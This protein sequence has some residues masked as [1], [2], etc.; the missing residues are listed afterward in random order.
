MSAEL[1]DPT[2]PREWLRR[3]RSSLSLARL[4][5]QGDVLLE[6]LCFE[7]QQ[8]A[9]KALKAVLVSRSLRFPRTHVISELLR[10]VVAGG[11]AIPDAVRKAEALTPYAVAAR[12]PDWGE[13][14]SPEEF[15]T[16]LALAVCTVDWASRLIGE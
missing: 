4:G 14:V 12:Y 16:A 10:L 7:A 13:D 5:R 15:E 9:E 8:A 2:D 1:R 11:T 6:D 3:A